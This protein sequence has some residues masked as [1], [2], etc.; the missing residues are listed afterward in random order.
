M[1]IK[2]PFLFFAVLLSFYLT[3][4][5]GTWLLTATPALIRSRTFKI[6]FS[7]RSPV[8][9]PVFGTKRL[10]K[11]FYISVCRKDC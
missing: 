4:V 3:L 6:R 5:Y 8:F 7:V 2:K 1:Y 10:K 11:T 9:P